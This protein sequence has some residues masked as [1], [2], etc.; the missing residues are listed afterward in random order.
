M[1]A[2]S[3]TRSAKASTAHHQRLTI[4]KRTAKSTD[5]MVKIFWIGM[6]LLLFANQQALR[7]SH[8]A[9]ALSA[10]AIGVTC[11]YP[12]YLWC[13]N[14]AK[15]MP[16]YPF[17]SLTYLWTFCL[18]LLSENPNVLKYSP[19]EHLFAAVCVVIFL[20]SGTWVWMRLVRRPTRELK[21]VYSLQADG[22]EVLFI[23][24]VG[25]GAILNMYVMGG[26]TFIPA[27]LF[28]IVRGIILGL[29]FL[30][31]FILAYRSGQGSMSQLKVKIFFVFLCANIV[32]SAA[33]LVLKTALT[34]FLLSTIAYVIGGRKLPTIPLIF[35]LIALLPLHYGKHEMRHK[36]WNNNGPHFV[37]PS[38]Y[39]AW[40]QEWFSYA[41]GNIGKEPDPYEKKE[42]K[43][44][45][46]ER[47]SV[48]HMLMMAQD[49]IPDPY[50]YLNGKTYSIIPILLV[51]RAFIANKPRSHEGTHMLNIHVGR[52]TYEDTIMTTIAWGL[53]PEAYA[54]FGV[55][56]C[57]GVGAFFGL[58]YGGVT[59]WAMKKP[60]FSFRTML[61]VLILSFALASTEWT[62]GVYAASLFQS[63][64]PI[65]GIKV[66]FMKI[67]KSKAKS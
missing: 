40:F 18:P 38:E 8:P 61:C 32:S 53:L 17:F 39:G 58:F 13:A 10:L 28:T 7:H 2:S 59:R 60:A 1:S 26:W 44:S 64:V 49:R 52:Q 24:M 3:P 29:S 12:V 22:A 47:S 48:I 65:V 36:Y 34:L 37:Q 19:Q 16:V 46:I 45:F 55:P 63:T 20:A 41:E 30:G 51:P 21:G 6:G 5:Q 57:A 25:L 31:I 11:M 42:K 33:A 4:P 15:G 35:G 23:T 27:K 43:E 54:N 9:T 50:P 14:R 56:G 67:R 66:V 62:A